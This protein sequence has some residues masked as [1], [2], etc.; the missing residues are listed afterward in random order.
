MKGGSGDKVGRRRGKGMKKKSIRKGRSL[1]W[2]R[3][4]DWW[5]VSHGRAINLR[6][7]AG[8]TERLFVCN[9]RAIYYSWHQRGDWVAPT[10][11][12]RLAAK[13]M[14]QQVGLATVY[15]AR[16]T[17]ASPKMCNGSASDCC[18]IKRMPAN[19]RRDHS[20]IMILHSCQSAFQRQPRTNA[21]PSSV[22]R[23]VHDVPSRKPLWPSETNFACAQVASFVLWLTGNLISQFIFVV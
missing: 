16:I 5:T 21:G 4:R 9:T 11:V 14:T 2:R 20:E 19:H 18:V 6:N 7:F 22:T 3:A 12:H 23:S 17:I 15:L 8:A 13:A 10:I 1:A